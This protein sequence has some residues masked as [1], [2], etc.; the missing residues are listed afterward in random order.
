MRCAA[1]SGVELI[2]RENNTLTINWH[3]VHKIFT[4]LQILEFNS[5]RRR[6]SVIA[7]RE[8]DG[9]ILVSK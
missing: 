4:V 1:R 3:G 9:A 6:M 2:A 5:Y 8:E 7:R